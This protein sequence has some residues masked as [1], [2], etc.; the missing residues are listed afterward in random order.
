L[1]AWCPIILK[2]HRYDDEKHIVFAGEVDSSP[3]LPEGMAVEI[4]REMRR[5]SVAEG[6]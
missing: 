2:Y 5:G 3:R 1:K 6:C 4:I